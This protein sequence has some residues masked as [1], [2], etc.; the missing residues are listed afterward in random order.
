MNVQPLDGVWKLKKPGSNELIDAQ[1]PG[2]VH[3]DLINAKIINDP[4][5]GDNEFKVAWVHETDWEYSRSF[6]VDDQILSADRVYLECD[7]LDTI[8]CLTLN[9]H[10]LGQTENMYIQHRFDVTDSL[11][12]GENS[13]RVHFTSPVNF[14]K[15]LLEQNPLICPGDSIPGSVYTR[16][17]PCQ[18]GW[19]WGPKLPTSGIWRPI[20]L[21]AYRIARIED[22]RIRQTHRRNGHV[23]L[24]VEVSL[25]RFRR[26]ACSM[27]LRLTHPDGEV[28]EREV[29]VTGS[30]TKCSF[31]VEN[32]N[33]WWPNGYGDQP[34]YT[35]DAALRCNTDELHT[36]TRRVG[37]RSIKLQQK[38]DRYGRCFTFVVN[39]VE[40]FCKGANWIPAD[41]FPARITDD[42]Y[43]KLITSAARANMNMLRVW[44]GGFYE[45]ERFYD[46]CDEHGILVWHDFMFSCAHYPT[47]KNY[48]DN[49][50]KDVEY[51]I[52]RLRN[53]ACLAL[54]CG[55]NEMEW[56]LA[57]GLG[58]EK[59]SLCKKQYHKVFHEHVP[60]IVNKLDPDTCY[61]P[62]SPSSGQPF[63]DPNSQDCGDGHYWDVWH[64]RV[65]FTSYRSQHHRFMSEFGFESLPAIE[66]VKSFAGNKDLNVTSHIMEC[67][68]KNSAGNGLILHYM[69][70]TFRFPKNFEMMCYV[71]QLLQAEAI[72]YG[73]EHWRRNRGRCMGTLY[74]QLNDC[75][76][77]SSWSSIDYFGRWKALHYAAKRFYAPIHLSVA[78]EG[79][80]AEIHVTNDTTKAAK[81]EVRWWLE[82]FDGT[83]LRKS[84]IKTR[85]EAEQNKLLADLDFAEELN[86]DV[87]RQAVLVHELLINGKSTGFGMTVFVP[88]KHLEMPSAKIKCEVK[89]DEHGSYVEVTSD[90]AARFVCLKVPKRDVIFS[91]NH[92][93]LPARRTAIIRIESDV[94]AASLA[95]IKAYSL[96]DS[97]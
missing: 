90:N 7:G 72:R 22:I 31:E 66:T 57:G 21:A 77:V 38:K 33:L 11:I 92:F 70:Q 93:D 52:T 23:A 64:Q 6:Q 63:N 28:E 29:K 73:V 32:P 40:I 76:P 58:G 80:R 82:K 68:Q 10:I 45:D 91:D 86:G 25:E 53:R 43:R 89:A 49:I 34:I 62:S 4:F 13:L 67:H 19:D 59:N 3:L 48:L 84:K 8:A 42:Q 26:N 24:S 37:L 65:P 36:F 18:W 75:W 41:Q 12:P 55:N 54:W 51:N 95:K 81:V 44:G 88:C 1:V 83:V 74:W 2:C 5:Y 97:Y 56:F 71:S 94:D 46:L 35:I 96:R 14:A 47:D 15:P 39:G 9:G 69:A 50:R 87:I 85:V 27:T 61:W 30:G 20:R 79:T 78:E 16:K 60:S 17:S